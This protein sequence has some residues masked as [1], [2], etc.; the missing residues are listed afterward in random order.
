M[1]RAGLMASAVKPD[2]MQ[3]Q[4]AIQV[5]NARTRHPYRAVKELP[6]TLP[7]TPQ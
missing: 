6:L 2:S 4:A 1:A 3:A 5:D 7:P